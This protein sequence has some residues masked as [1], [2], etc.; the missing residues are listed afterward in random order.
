ML[1]FLMAYKVTMLPTPLIFQ[2]LRVLELYVLPGYTAGLK[3]ELL[4][5]ATQGMRRENTSY[6]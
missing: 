3:S 1:S 2:L 6:P 4:L 5:P